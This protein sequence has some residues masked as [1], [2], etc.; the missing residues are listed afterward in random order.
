MDQASGRPVRAFLIVDIRGYTAFTAARGDEAASRLAA[1]FADIVGQAAE[2]W[3]GRLLELRGDEALCVFDDAAASLRAAVELQD[4]F[5]DETAADPSMP[6]RTGIGLASGDAVPL[7]AGYRG[8]ALNLAARLCAVS[9]AGEVHASRD[10]IEL[11]GQLQEL[12]YEAVE[13]LQLKGLAGA[14]RAYRI[15]GSVPH[16]AHRIPAAAPPPQASAAQAA[17]PG[18]SDQLAGRAA[19]MRWLRWHWRRARHGHGRVVLVHGPPGVGKTR[20]AH[21][22]A[23]VARQD[24][25]T[26]RTEASMLVGTVGQPRVP[27]QDRPLLIVVDSDETPGTAAS[28]PMPTWPSMRDRPTLVV[29]IGEAGKALRVVDRGERAELPRLA[30]RPLDL[31]GVRALGAQLAPDVADELP[32]ARILESSGGMP[33]AAHEAVV[34]WAA[35]LAAERSTAST[36][37]S[38]PAERSSFVGRVDELKAAR[39]LLKGSRLLTLTGPPGTGKTRLALRL[40][41]TASEDYP[42]GTSFV[43]LAAVR[44]EA[45]VAGAVARTL[46]LRLDP[47]ATALDVVAAYLAER[48]TLLVLDNFEQLH[49]A[50]GD[51][52]RLLE[53]APR[54]DILVTSRSSL[55]LSGEQVYPVPP[56]ELPRPGAVTVE[57]VAQADASALFVLRARNVDP[58]FDLRPDNAEL[59]AD[60]ASRL[61]GLPLAIELAAARVR[62]LG[63]HELL[64]HLQQR[65]PILTG[66]R[67]DEVAHHQTMR[68]A[69]AWSYELL[70]DEEQHLL[71]HL[72][73][74]RGGAGLAAAAR[75][76]DRS[77]V[78]TLDTMEALVMQSL[79]HRVDDRPH[80]RF[81]LLE[82]IREFAGHE[83]AGHGEQPK[84]IARLI[85]VEV[86]LVRQLEPAF[87]SNESSEATAQLGLEIDNLR[88]ALD[89]ALSERDV[90][91]ALL[92][93]ACPWR[94]WQSIGQL[95]E[96]RAWVERALALPG[97]SAPARAGATAAHGGLCY[98]LGDFSGSRDS[99]L[100]A[101]DLYTAT[102]DRAAEANAIYSLS[103]V[104]TY[105]GDLDTAERYADEAMELARAVGDE[106]MIAEVL[107]AQF[108]IAWKRG[109]LARARG[110]GEAALAIATRLG[111]SAMIATQLVGLAGVAHMG[112]DT[113]QALRRADEALELAVETENTHT[114]IFALDAIASFAAERLPAPAARLCAAAAA[115]RLE[116]GGGWTLSVMGVECAD[117]AAGALLEPDDLE[118]ARTGGA[119]LDLAGATDV[120]RAILAEARQR[121]TD[122]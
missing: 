105:E 103:L 60:I 65:L 109:E 122:G 32:I 102:G 76:A 108:L 14:Q 71:R 2:A 74:F 30:V 68:D 100:R 94:F 49:G 113:D 59:I 62:T 92:L 106:A 66:G 63:C 97:G 107:V 85:A 24:G 104:A 112:G 111:L 56:L 52:G 4:V 40:A 115:L 3:T 87:E 26:V 118:R 90:E 55:E 39:A 95:A 110:L 117:S 17:R 27:G 73:V 18:P 1:R 48:K 23:E 72:S 88:A 121:S 89:H 70:S 78:E 47:E 20:L 41:S 58:D 116:H 54:L 84:A 86:S 53:A 12:R 80:A 21:E 7:G 119:V 57:G 61:E 33:G 67:A 9:A 51:V 120:A 96:G 5:A 69:I 98:W 93:A 25:A 22:L 43:P 8:S 77:E 29:V 46:Q 44:D 45:L 10:L 15:S 64:E 6:M 99:Y 37:G 75:V 83:L 82:L 16:E 11:V 35:R 34:E 13:G 19:E 36:S 28:A 114:Q 101:R 42:D 50:A 31:D 38:L 91:S 81:A 79:V